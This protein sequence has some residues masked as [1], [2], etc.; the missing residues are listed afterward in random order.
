MVTSFRV[1]FLSTILE[2]LFLLPVHSIFCMSSVCQALER[3]RNSSIQ[4]G[5]KCLT[6]W[7]QHSYTNGKLLSI[8]SQVPLSPDFSCGSSDGH[9]S[10][11]GP[12]LQCLH[13]VSL[14]S[15]HPKGLHLGKQGQQL[16]RGH[17]FLHQPLIISDDFWTSSTSSMFNKFLLMWH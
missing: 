6:S 14:C 2:P 12:L 10:S 3:H 5:Q 17:A 7:N 1:S 8:S 16:W 9:S 4:D 13:T 15:G 11:T